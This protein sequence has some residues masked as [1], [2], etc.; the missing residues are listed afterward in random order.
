MKF[1]VQRDYIIKRN[2]RAKKYNAHN[3]SKEKFLRDIECE[4]YEYEMIRTGAWEDDE[5]WQVDGISARFGTID[6]CVSSLLQD[7]DETEY[8]KQETSLNLT[9]LDISPTSNSS[10]ILKSPLKVTDIMST[11]GKYSRT[12]ENTFL[13]TQY[14]TIKCSKC[15]KKFEDIGL[16]K[17]VKECPKCENNVETL[18]NCH[19][20][21]M[22]RKA[23]DEDNI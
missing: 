3:R 21:Y 10:S 12:M 8:S 1:V 20:C 17:D 7:V 13:G 2:Q 5:R 11:L 22:I 6:V 16:N 15:K 14:K 19:T 23:K 9:N 4:M 18:C